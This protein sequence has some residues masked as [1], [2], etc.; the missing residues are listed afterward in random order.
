MQSFQPALMR[1]HLQGLTDKPQESKAKMM[2]ILWLVTQC[3][4]FMYSITAM[5]DAGKEYNHGACCL[6]A[7]RCMCLFSY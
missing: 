5:V 2:S 6:E 7:R 4:F 3:F 1:N